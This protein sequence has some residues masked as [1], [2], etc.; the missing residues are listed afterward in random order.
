MHTGASDLPVNAVDAAV[1][2]PIPLVEHVRV[3]HENQFLH[4]VGLEV[5]DDDGA[6]IALDWKGASATSS[7]TVQNGDSSFPIDGKHRTKWPS[8][9]HTSN[10]PKEWWEVRLPKPTAVKTLLVLNRHTHEQ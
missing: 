5:Y 9:C 2:S 3:E 1:E 6:N 4:I 8:G 10:G 7:S